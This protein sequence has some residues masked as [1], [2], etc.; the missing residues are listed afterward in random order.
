MC[1]TSGSSQFSIQ[2]FLLQLN[3]NFALVLLHML[4]K[5]RWECRF[6][7]STR[8]IFITT[9]NTVIT[10]VRQTTY[11]VSFCWLFQSENQRD[12][13][14]RVVRIL[15]WYVWGVLSAGILCQVT[16]WLM[17]DAS[18]WVCG[19]IF[20]SRMSNDDPWR[21]TT[22]LSLKFGQH[23][24][25]DSPRYPRWTRISDMLVSNLRKCQ[26]PSLLNSHDKEYSGV[27]AW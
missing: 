3:L 16:G 10:D 19:P 26:Y 20:D 27:D 17:L 12:R 22:P 25:S 4:F 7:H 15:Q 24:P 23:S 2:S 21:W 6:K 1:A 8:K 18:G 13:L 14:V 11:S 9:T 5:F